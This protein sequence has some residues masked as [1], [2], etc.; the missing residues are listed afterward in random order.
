MPVNLVR[1]FC[2]IQLTASFV[3]NWF[4]ATVAQNAP[5]STSTA[6]VNEDD[7]EFNKSLRNLMQIRSFAEACK[8]C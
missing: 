8:L 3:L 4:S 7:D 5:A 6:V 2:C 1:V